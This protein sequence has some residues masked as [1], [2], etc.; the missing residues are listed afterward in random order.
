MVRLL[1]GAVN[2]QSGKAHMPSS[3]AS[4]RND[5]NDPDKKLSRFALNMLKILSGMALQ[6]IKL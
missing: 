4:L 1:N 2:L 6:L 5:V 3:V